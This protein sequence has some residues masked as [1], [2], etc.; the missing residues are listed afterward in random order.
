MALA[1]RAV[2]GT[3]TPSGIE[4]VY[5][6]VAPLPLLLSVLAPMAIVFAGGSSGIGRIWI[7]R[8]TWTGVALSAALLLVGVGLIVR[9]AVGRVTWGWPLGAAVVVAATPVTILALYFGLWYLL[10]LLLRSR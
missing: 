7:D 4:R 9:A 3:R 8:F 6:A 1:L 2:G 10:P 5:M